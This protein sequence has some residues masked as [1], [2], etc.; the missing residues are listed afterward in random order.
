MIIKKKKK[1]IN[2]NSTVKKNKKSVE[3]A[4]EN[5]ITAQLNL[6]CYNYKILKDSEELFT[7]FEKTY[8]VEKVDFATLAA[9]EESYQ[10]LIVG[11]SDALTD[12][13]ISWIDFLR[14]INSEDFSFDNQN[15]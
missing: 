15:L 7:L 4:Y 6:N 14:E 13:Y 3:I 5:F 1:K 10:D 9:V 8:K 11:Y 12:Y 2:Y